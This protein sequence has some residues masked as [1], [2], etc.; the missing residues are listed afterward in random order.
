M[1]T[2]RPK[3]EP[4]GDSQ[5]PLA[6]ELPEAVAA[7]ERAEPLN[8]DSSRSVASAAVRRRSQRTQTAMEIADGGA[9]SG[10]GAEAEPTR[11]IAPEPQRQDVARHMASAGFNSIPLAGHSLFVDPLP[12]APT[13]T[14]KSPAYPSGP[15]NERGA[16]MVPDSRYGWNPGNP[17][18]PPYVVPRGAIPHTGWYGPQPGVRSISH[19]VVDPSLLPGHS[20]RDR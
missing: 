12:L 14:G 19:S 2:P 1:P 7:S 15:G 10:R 5:L 16:F 20:L 8:A 9:V 13:F 17:L 4:R 11:V 6:G 3:R 18:G